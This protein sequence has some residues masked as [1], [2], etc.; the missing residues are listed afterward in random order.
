MKDIDAHI[1][2]ASALIDVEI[3]AEWRPGVRNFLHL[4]KEMSAILEATPLH[5]AEFAERQGA[6]GNEFQ[7]SLDVLE[8]HAAEAL[9]ANIN[10]NGPAHSRG[11]SGFACLTP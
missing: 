4:A 10:A 8:H 5:E 3:N 2:T 7:T 9:R 11:L 1:D 6:G